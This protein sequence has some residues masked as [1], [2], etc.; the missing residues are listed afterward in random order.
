M[1]GG[2][3]VAALSGGHVGGGWSG[4]HMSGAGMSSHAALGAARIGWLDRQ[5]VR[6]AAA[7]LLGHGR[8]VHHRGRVLSLAVGT[9]G[10]RATTIVGNGYQRRWVCV[11]SG[12]AVTD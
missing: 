12:L 7:G 1:R 3:R 8:F 10:E 4:G 5:S 11:A 6:G 2:H 9:G